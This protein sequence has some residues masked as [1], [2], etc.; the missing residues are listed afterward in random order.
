[1]QICVPPYKQPRSVLLEISAEEW[2]P[3][4]DQTPKATEKQSSSRW[5]TQRWSWFR[6]WKAWWNHMFLMLQRLHEE[7]E[8]VGATNLFEH[9]HNALEQLTV[10][11]HLAVSPCTFIFQSH[12]WT[13]N[14]LEFWGK[15]KT[16]V[17]DLLVPGTSVLY[18]GFFFFPKQK[19]V[20]LD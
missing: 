10:W 17:F 11:S 12:F 20:S 15:D 18:E 2:L 19:Q 13:S 14:P 5:A 16:I 6:R 8:T 3:Y 1:M 9:Q 7:R 4:L